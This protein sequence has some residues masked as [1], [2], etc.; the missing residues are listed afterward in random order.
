M[1]E[2]E[3]LK[4]KLVEAEAEIAALKLQVSNLTYMLKKEMTASGGLPKLKEEK[5]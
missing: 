2:I 5:G 3:L 1:T 4:K